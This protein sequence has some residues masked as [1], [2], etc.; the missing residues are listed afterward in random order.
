MSFLDLGTDA[1]AP[2]VDYPDYCARRR[3]G[4]GARR[5]RSRD[6]GL[7][8][9]RGRVHRRRQGAGRARLLRRRYVHRAS[10]RRA[11]R[12][13]H[14]VSGRTGDRPGAGRR[15]RAHVPA[16]PV[17]RPGAPSAAGGQDHGHRGRVQLPDRSLA[18]P[19][20]EHLARQHRPQHADLRRAAPPGLERSRRGRDVQSDDLRKGHGP[21][22]PSTRRR[23]A[24]WPSRARAPKTIYWALA[25][26]DIQGAADILRATYDLTDGRDGYVS[27]EC[28]PSVANDTQA[29]IDDG[30]AICGR[31]S[32][33]RT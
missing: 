19:G 14:P 13:Q 25:I 23:R 24:R 18:A 29:T 30:R 15:D 16:R 17:Q 12:R 1:A 28:A 11:R 10:G 9:G 8:L 22:A 7:R 21:A 4:R 26:E 5:R 3:R 20:S 6:H 31:G 2:P 32:I 33:G 27:L